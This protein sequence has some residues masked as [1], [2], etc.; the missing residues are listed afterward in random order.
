MPRL[1]GIWFRKSNGF[2]YS[3]IDGVQHKL[4][5]DRKKAEGKLKQLLR[6]LGSGP[7]GPDP[8]IGK[9]C[10]LFLEHSAGENESCTFDL[11]QM[12]LQS[13]CDHV[14]KNKKVVS[15]REHHVD[16]WVKAKPTWGASTRVRAKAILLAA[17]N[18]ACRKG[19]LGT[20][21]L[22]NVRPGTVGRRERILTQGERK[23]IRNAV[24]GP[25][26]DF[27]L[28]LEL[29]GARPFSEVCRVTA[30]DVDLEKGTWTLTNWKN[31]KKQQGR[32][33]VIYL[34]PTLAELTKELMKKY[35]EGPLFRGHR[36]R[37]WI[38]QS[39]TW[40]LRDLACKLRIEG[41]S[42]YAWRHTY[43]TECLAKGMSA[44]IVAELVGS[45][46]QTIHKY[47]SHL[48]QKGDVLRDAALQAVSG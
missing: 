20:H 11:H 36:A 9:V 24:K 46:V 34:T 26:A 42:A 27:I 28:A 32:K 40:R 10:D 14:G 38:K 4:H 48:D 1:P 45:S 43:I 39:V 15:L 3:T 29:T 18:F 12:F 30:A 35:P 25:I 47:Y 33:R 21:P 13:F 31:S 8:S 7:A 6:D 17:L 19:H 2:Y 16:S 23:T 41:L 37:P 44:S 5:P 22:K